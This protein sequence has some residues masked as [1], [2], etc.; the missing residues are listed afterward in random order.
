LDLGHRSKAGYADLRRDSN[1]DN[2][3]SRQRRRSQEPF[4]GRPKPTNPREL[5]LSPPL[6]MRPKLPSQKARMPSIL[7]MSA[8]ALFS[9]FYLQYVEEYQ[10]CV[11]CYILRYLTIGI[12]GV[13]AFGTFTRSF[14]GDVAAVLASLE[15]GRASCRKEC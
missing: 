14:T 1:T 13:S 11:Y 9:S 3:H 12:L 7:L 5:A 15:I 2:L 10:P 6:K 8:V 4:C